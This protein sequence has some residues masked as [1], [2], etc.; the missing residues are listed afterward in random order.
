MFTKDAP[1]IMLTEIHRQA[2]ERHHPPCHH[3]A[4]GDSI[5]L[6][7]TTPSSKNAAGRRR[8]QALR[9]GQVICGMN[10]TR[11]QL[12]NAMRRAAGFEDGWL[13]TGRGEK[14]TRLKNQNDLG[15]INGM[16]VT[17]ITS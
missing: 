7:N 5:G 17:L 10:A 9:G 6:A 1:D 13:P 12:N 4:A 3:G 14:I 11:M 15:L 8:K 2:R 16:F